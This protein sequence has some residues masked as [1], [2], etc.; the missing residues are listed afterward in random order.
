[1]KKQLKFEI[2]ITCILLFG[3]TYDSLAPKLKYLEFSH[4]R[5]GSDL[6]VYNHEQYS[7]M[8]YTHIKYYSSTVDLFSL[9]PQSIRETYK[10]NLQSFIENNKGR[11]YVDLVNEGVT[12]GLYTRQFAETKVDHIRGLQRLLES[13]PEKSDISDW[14]MKSEDEII[15]SSLLTKPEKDKLLLHESLVKAVIRWNFEKNIELPSR[16]NANKANARI[17]EDCSFWSQLACWVGTITGFSAAGDTV[18]KLG[19]AADGSVLGAIISVGVGLATAYQTCQCTVNKN[20]CGQALDASFPYR[21]YNIGDA[22]ICRAVGYG[23]IIPSQFVFTFWKNDNLITANQFYSNF[24]TN[25]YLYIPPGY[26]TTSINDIAVQVQTSCNPNWFTSNYFGWF[27]PS[28]LGKPY[29]AINGNNNLPASS[30]GYSS[31]TYTADGPLGLSTIQ[32][33]ITSSGYPGYSASGTI[34]SGATSAQVIIKWNS[35]PGFANLKC[36]ITSACKTTTNYYSV[37]VY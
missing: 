37:R 4:A 25:D 21:C 24:T 7:E 17:D 6:S 15:E 33:Q 13:G 9:L 5:I 23:N 22:L 2:V 10:E 12:N 34:L 20:F 29:F 35:T 8:F 28:D 27:V 11:S 26:I 3:C 32:W 30:T 31:Y 18:E 36:T 19:G 16:F 14:F 1:M